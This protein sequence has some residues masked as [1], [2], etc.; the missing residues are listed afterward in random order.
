MTIGGVAFIVCAAAM[1]LGAFATDDG[2]ARITLLI[3]AIVF[4]PCGYLFFWIAKKA[5]SFPNVSCST[6]AMM[7]RP[8]PGVTANRRAS[9]P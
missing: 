9:R 3:L 6:A 8:A 5:G 1:V 2:G 4:F 7:A